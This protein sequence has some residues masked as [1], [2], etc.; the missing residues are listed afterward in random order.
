[1]HHRGAI[2][3]SVWYEGRIKGHAG[4]W[5][6]PTWASK[7]P[8]NIT[9]HIFKVSKVSSLKG[10]NFNPRYS[11]KAFSIASNFQTFQTLKLFR[12]QVPALKAPFLHGNF[13]FD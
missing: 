1:M 6:D 11:G 7:V 4:S 13:K 5:V 9:K 3:A 8:T 10:L 12:N 2:D